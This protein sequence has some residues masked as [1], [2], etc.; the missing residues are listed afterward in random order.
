MEITKEAMGLAGMNPVMGIS[1]NVGSF[2]INVT[3][4]DKDL[5]DDNNWKDGIGLTK[6]LDMDDN[7][8]GIDK[9]GKFFAKH[10]FDVMKRKDIVEAYE[11]VDDMSDIFYMINEE[12]N[13][14][15]EDRPSHPRNFIYTLATGHEMLTEDQ[16]KF[17][18]KLKPLDEGIISKFKNAFK[19]GK[20]KDFIF[21]E[22]KEAGTEKYSSEG[23][24]YFYAD[25]EGEKPEY[26]KE[27][28]GSL[29]NAT[30][31]FIQLELDKSDLKNITKAQFNKLK[32]MKM[33]VY[34]ASTKL[35]KIKK[36]DKY[37][38]M[39]TY[40]VP[41]NQMK[42]EVYSFPDLIKA[43]DIQVID[44][45]SD[46][47]KLK[48]L[49]DIIKNLLKIAGEFG[50]QFKKS[51]SFNK[52]EI[53]REEKQRFIGDSAKDKL[54]ILCYDIWDFSKTARADDVI[55]QYTG[56]TNKYFAACN[57][58]LSPFGYKLD[59][60]DGDWD[61]GWY[62]IKKTGKSIHESLAVGIELPKASAVASG[63]AGTYGA[64]TRDQ[65]TNTRKP[66]I[67]DTTLPQGT[68][69]KI[70]TDVMTDESARF[71]LERDPDDWRNPLNEQTGFH[72]Y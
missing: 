24:A 18:D 48:Q 53:D 56:L 34:T 3:N 39:L 31:H 8:Y 54:P 4:H 7:L 12:L 63:H 66:Y 28:N 52:E 55:Q 60:Y 23:G 41:F 16:M 37:N 57:K 71:V 59:F 45:K 5:D 2:I 58:Y 26:I 20:Y 30:L 17:D 33:C 50:P 43:A 65:K 35:F 29:H 72:R 46:G 47:K 62:C 70:G 69:R 11:C 51:I 22:V 9:N 40:A 25:N 32:N 27:R 67:P 13:M 15:Y 68:G 14:P 61:D 1:S 10:K 49:D 38:K 36:R 44:I 19:I 6:S 64:Y 21:Y 42:K